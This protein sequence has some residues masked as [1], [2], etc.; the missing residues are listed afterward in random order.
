MVCDVLVLYFLKHHELYHS[1]KYLYVN[2]NDTFVM[3]D[4]P[5]DGQ[6]QGETHCDGCTE[7][8]TGVLVV[9]TGSGCNW[10]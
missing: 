4:A 10:V 9:Y 3:V 7:V 6:Y 1:K 5:E 2:D 8:G